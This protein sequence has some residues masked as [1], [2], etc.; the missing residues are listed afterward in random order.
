[1]FQIKSGLLQKVSF[2]LDFKSLQW[3]IKIHCF[4]KL[5]KAAK[6]VS[7]RQIITHKVL[8][9]NLYDFCNK[10]GFCFQTDNVSWTSI[11]FHHYRQLWSAGSCFGYVDS[12]DHGDASIIASQD[13]NAA[14]LPLSAQRF[15]KGTRVYKCKKL[16]ANPHGE[17]NRV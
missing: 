11:F 10:F 9:C 12:D 16:L 8:L 2:W 3:L 6:E 7:F 13:V 17:F 1:M 5:P 14:C 4:W 15:N